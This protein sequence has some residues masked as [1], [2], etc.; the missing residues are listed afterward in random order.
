MAHDSDGWKFQDWAAAPDEGLGLLPLMVEREREV[1]VCKEIILK[2]R[3][4]DSE[5]Q[6]ARLFSTTRTFEN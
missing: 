6:K 4:E 5:T 2:E 1:G 3:I